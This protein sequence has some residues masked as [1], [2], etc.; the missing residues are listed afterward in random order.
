MK[1]VQRAVYECETC[2]TEHEE[3]TSIQTCELCGNDICD[4]CENV[5]NFF[6]DEDYYKNGQREYDEKWL[7]TYICND[8]YE[9]IIA[10][11]ENIEEVDSEI[12]KY[13]AEETVKLVR[14]KN[15]ELH[16]KIKEIIC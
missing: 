3:E 14:K 6:L 13:I 2:H 12:E 7:D 4:N 16:K 9:K 15:E 11:D 5:M 1:V 10:S 8:C